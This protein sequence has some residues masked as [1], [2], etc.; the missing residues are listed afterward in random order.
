MSTKEQPK[1]LTQLLSEYYLSR[2]SSVARSRLLVGAVFK[3]SGVRLGYCELCGFIQGDSQSGKC[4]ECGTCM[5]CKKNPS[6][7]LC[8]ECLFG[9]DMYD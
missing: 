4:P 9:G 2:V 3:Y 8:V 1:N 6:A 5:F 7:I